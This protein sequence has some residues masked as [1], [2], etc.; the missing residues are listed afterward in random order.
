MKINHVW[1][2]YKWRSKYTASSCDGV[3]TKAL[4]KQVPQ[5]NF[6]NCDNILSTRASG[7][8]VDVYGK[9]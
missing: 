7:L 1:T 9:L 3:N 5:A 4:D 8:D 6:I 2:V